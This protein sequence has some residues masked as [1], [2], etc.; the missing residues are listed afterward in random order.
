MHGKYLQ[1]NS[2]AGIALVRVKQKLCTLKEIKGINEKN[3]PKCYGKDP[4]K[5]YSPL[6]PTARDTKYRV[7]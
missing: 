1:C 2:Q 4:C 6:H 5:G 3:P 7:L